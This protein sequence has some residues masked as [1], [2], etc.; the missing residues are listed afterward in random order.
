MDLSSIKAIAFLGDSPSAP[1][2]F[3][4]SQNNAAKVAEICGRHR[5]RKADL[6]VI[7]D[8]GRL[9]DCPDFSSV[10][11]V[12]AIVARGL[13]VIT[14]ETWELARGRVHNIPRES[15]TR[16]VSLATTTKFIFEYEAD[17]NSRFELMLQTIQECAKMDG[18]KWIVR[19]LPKKKKAVEAALAP[20]G[21]TVI[22][23][24]DTKTVRSWI[25]SNRRIVNT[26]GS[27]YN[28]LP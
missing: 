14:N 26:C 1:L 27:K 19:Q 24:V 22:K 5:S 16:H 13:P 6:I 4:I 28:I 20:T 2:P 11:Q 17:F 23:L 9:F 21:F 8:L 10:N 12:F 25:L 7:D 18:C 15:V 3:P